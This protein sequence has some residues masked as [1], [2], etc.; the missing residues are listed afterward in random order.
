MNIIKI[1][2][3]NDQGQ[4]VGTLDN[5][6]VFVDNACIDE[7]VSIQ[8][9][10]DK[11]NYSIGKVLKHI[12][13]S[14]KRVNPKCN[15]YDQCG[16]CNIMHIGYDS[17]LKIKNKKVNDA[18][19]KIGEITEYNKE[20]ILFSPN[21]FSYRNK[22]LLPFGYI[23]GKITVGSFKKNTHDVLD[24]DYCYLY[25][26]MVNKII[27]IIKDF[28]ND[29][30]ISV[31]DE[32]SKRGIL[33]HILIREAK[34]NDI[35][36]TII[37]NS[38]KLPF[39][40]DLIKILSKIDEVVELNLCINTKFTNVPITKDIEK[41]YIKK[42]FLD[43]IGNNTYKI[44]P[45]TF[46]QVN[47]YTTEIL[48]SAVKSLIDFNNINTLI[49]L[50]CGMGTIGQYLIDED[51]N[52][53]GIE[54]NK[55]AVKYA[56]ESTKRNNIKNAKYICDKAKNAIQSINYD[57]DKTV[58]IV[59]PP[60]KGCSDEVIEFLVN[61]GVSQIVYVSCKPSTLARDLKKIVSDNKYKVSK[62]I[63]VDM[64]PQT[65]HVESVVGLQRV[66]A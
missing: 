40:D 39:A 61:S 15:I 16:G 30:K 31:Y 4:G 55:N 48:Y 45:D 23:N 65:M 26:D 43:M 12:K 66:D 62:V 2:D 6:V 17:Q 32:K 64:F 27:T 10:Q 11:K 56:R 53:I 59:D 36:I 38:N 5:K 41:F 49:D 34:N 51:V 47:K 7:E 8:I 20:D 50:Y 18:I 24:F 14:D 35:S 42:E 29:K 21:E 9:I 25:S 33:R 46:F 44:L 1:R 22:C 52:I 37:A 3:I 54:E 19:E 13:T 58:I 60:R 57:K 63:P 28:F